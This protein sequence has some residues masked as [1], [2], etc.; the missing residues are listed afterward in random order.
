MLKTFLQ[1]I[2]VALCKKELQKNSQ[3]SKNENIL[4]KMAKNNHRAK[5]KN[6]Q[7]RHFGSKI[8]NA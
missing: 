7:N 4:G 6:L 1:H 2:A 8:K 3:Y 5:V